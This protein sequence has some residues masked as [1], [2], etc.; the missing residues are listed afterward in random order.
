MFGLRYDFLGIDR[1]TPNFRERD[2]N[3]RGY[4]ELGIGA[5]FALEHVD[6]WLEQFDPTLH[7][8]VSPYARVELNYSEYLA[9]PALNRGYFDHSLQIDLQLGYISRD[10]AFLQFMGGGQLYSQSAPQYNVSVGF[11]GYRFF[12]I[13]GETLINLAVTYRM[14]IARRLSWNLGP[15]FVEDIYAQVFSS[16]GNIWSFDPDGRRQ[17]PLID[18]ALNGRRVLA[19]VGLDVRIGNFWQEVETN[20]GTTLRAVYRAVPFTRCPDTPPAPN[21]LDIDGKPG[22]MFYA[23]VGGGF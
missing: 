8:G 13:R 7:G 16:V 17:I 4:R 15:L 20:I 2:I 12:S 23:I 18:P 10:I 19:D 5:Y 14:P 9:L 6:P 3:K 11:G 21:C 22:F 1:S